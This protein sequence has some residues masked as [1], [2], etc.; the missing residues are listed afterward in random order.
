MAVTRKFTIWSPA[1]KLA[2]TPDLVVQ[3]TIS[4]G[5]LITYEDLGELDYKEL[6]ETGDLTLQEDSASARLY[7]VSLADSIEKTVLLNYL[8]TLQTDGNP[9]AGIPAQKGLIRFR[10]EFWRY[11]LEA[12]ITG[13][14][15]RTAIGD[16]VTISTRQ[17][18]YYEAPCY[19]LISDPWRGVLGKSE[20]GTEET[21]G[22]TADFAVLERIN[23]IARRD[24][25]LA[26][27][28]SL[29]QDISA[30]SINRFPKGSPPRKPNSNGFV[31]GVEHTPAQV[32]LFSGAKRDRLTW[33]VSAILTEAEYLKLGALFRWQ[34]NRLL[35]QLDGRL[36]WTDG[37]FYAD[38][39]VTPTRTFVA[40][41]TSADGQTYGFPVVDCE[42]TSPEAQ[43]YGGS[44]GDIR[45][46]C[47]FQV[48]E[49]RS[50]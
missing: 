10:D 43:I 31:S 2:G 8:R 44:G 40:N 34:Q 39:E 12:D 15:F 26:I 7:T 11:D 47:T 30:L 20:G 24:Y 46:L 1:A 22:E 18:S 32:P 23:P 45:Y 14:N 28:L 19:L 49:V 17:Q 4:G 38:P 5:D 3:R 25:T 21:S 48:T 35:N 27:N 9:T 13:V 37:I 41:L 16:P 50:A 6:T 29:P 33:D 42:I 36:T